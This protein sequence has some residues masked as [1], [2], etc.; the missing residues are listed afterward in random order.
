M[1]MHALAYAQS[2]PYIFTYHIG[3]MLTYALTYADA[4]AEHA[5]PHLRVPLPHLTYADVC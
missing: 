4:C 1:L 3:R 2:M 5:V